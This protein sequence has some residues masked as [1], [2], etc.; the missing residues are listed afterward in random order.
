MKS[1]STMIVFLYFT[2]YLVRN[3]H[4]TLY[5]PDLTRFRLG[6]F[7]VKS[8]NNCPLLLAINL[9]WY[10]PRKIFVCNLIA[11]LS[12][13]IWLKF[14]IRLLSNYNEYP[15]EVAVDRAKLTSFNHINSKESLPYK[16]T[17]PRR[18]P[19]TRLHDGKH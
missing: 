10:K 9:I 6:H 4:D 13:H 14:L 12:Q 18:K 8:V 7:M 15:K 11:I 16:I 5:E 19:D 3:T 17:H 1:A 2:V